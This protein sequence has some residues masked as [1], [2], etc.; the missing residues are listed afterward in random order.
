[1]ICPR[2]PTIV[3]FLPLF[4]IASTGAGEKNSAAPTKEAAAWKSLFDG[5]SLSGWK[6]AGYIGGGKIEV[7]DGAMVLGKGE[8]MTGITSTRG[9]F[10]AMDYEVALEGKKLAGDDF[11]CTTT[12][13]VGKDFCSLVVGGWGGQVVGLSS[14]NHLDA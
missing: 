7:K 2:F 5:K 4:V 10:P 8:R 11:F 14:L 13:P 3:C 1:M 12:F 9:D 6:S